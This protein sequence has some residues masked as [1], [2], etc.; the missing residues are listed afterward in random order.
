MVTTSR[1]AESVIRSQ[2]CATPLALVL[3]R[4][5]FSKLHDANA[6][7]DTAATARYSADNSQ[8]GSL[9]DVVESADAPP[10]PQTIAAVDAIERDLRAAR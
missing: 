4:T 1:N 6:R 10:T 3:M 2:G 7:K 9:L 8:L 5:S